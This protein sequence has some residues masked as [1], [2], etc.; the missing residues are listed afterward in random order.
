[1]HTRSNKTSKEEI[2]NENIKI[3]KQ[4]SPSVRGNKKNMT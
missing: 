2:K 4:P 1:M 3:Y